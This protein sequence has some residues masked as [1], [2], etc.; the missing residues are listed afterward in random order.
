MKK[1]VRRLF[2]P[3]GLLAVLMV[4]VVLLFG[5][6]LLTLGSLK[7]VDSHPL[8]QMAYHGEYGFSD[9]LQV[10]AKNDREIESFIMKKLLKGIDLNLNIAS[11]GCSAFCAW[12][13]QGQRIFA[14]NFDFDPAPA[15]LLEADPFD[16]CA[17]V[18]IVNLAFAGYSE[19]YL[20]ATYTFSSF[21]T[22]ASPYLP[23][24]GMNEKGVAMALLAVPHAEPPTDAGKVMLNTTTMIRLVLDHAESVEEAI[25]LIKEHTLYFSGGVEC[26]YL[27]SDVAGDS[28]IIEFV[29][30]DIKVIRAEGKYQAITNFIVYE[31]RNEGEGGTEFKRYD[32][33]VNRLEATGG[34]LSEQEAMILLADVKIPGKTQWSA[35]YNLTTGTVQICMGEKF[36]QVYSFASDVVLGV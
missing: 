33:I 11:A 18:S 29:D 36:D 23:F 15:L 10:G 30:N 3:L 2:I 21:L 19:D 24:D 4:T 28:A 34:V 35:V 25:A 22:L 17:S 7:Q 27:V 16:G 1:L 8:Y 20:P 12:N 14:R 32:T 13:G 6:E 31:G 5:K 9:F 26:H